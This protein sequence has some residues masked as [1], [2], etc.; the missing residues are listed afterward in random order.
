MENNEIL[1][2]LSGGVGAITQ[3]VL[4]AASIILVYKNKNAGSILMLVGSILMFICL[5]SNS[6]LPILTA[7]QGAESLAKTVVLL[8]VIRQ[9]PFLLYTLGVIIFAINTTKK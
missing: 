2:A 7:R 6:L 8:Q 9:I 3:L 4:I 1:L 5:L